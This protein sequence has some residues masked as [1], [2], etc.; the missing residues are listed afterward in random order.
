M[1][2]F[3]MRAALIL[4]YKIKL[5][6]HNRSTV[7]ST[8]P[9]MKMGHA[10]QQWEK[11]KSCTLAVVPPVGQVTIQ[12]PWL[13]GLGLFGTL[14]V[15]TRSPTLPDQR[16]EELLPGIISDPPVGAPNRIRSGCGIL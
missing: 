15:S 8:P 16:S 1:P 3:V 7:P 10:N 5:I 9:I 4:S 14:Q 11:E 13:L 2:H 12:S 6:V